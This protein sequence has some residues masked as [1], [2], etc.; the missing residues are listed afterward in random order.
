MVKWNTQYKEILTDLMKGIQAINKELKDLGSDEDYTYREP[1]QIL[2]SYMELLASSPDNKDAP[3]TSPSSSQKMSRWFFTNDYKPKLSEKLLNKKAS[4]LMGMIRRLPEE[5]AREAIRE[6]YKQR[7][8]QYWEHEIKRLEEIIKRDLKSWWLLQKSKSDIDGEIKKAKNSEWPGGAMAE[9]CTKYGKK[10]EDTL[11]KDAI[12]ILNAQKMNMQYYETDDKRDDKFRDIQ[13]VKIK[14]FG[15]Y[16][17]AFCY[18]YLLLRLKSPKIKPEVTLD[19][20]LKQLNDDDKDK[21]KNTVTNMMRGQTKLLYEKLLELVKE[22]PEKI[23]NKDIIII[24]GD[25]T[26]ED[27]KMGIGGPTRLQAKNKN[28]LTEIYDNIIKLRTDKKY[29]L[30]QEGTWAIKD[31]FKYADYINIPEEKIKEIRMKILPRFNTEFINKW[32]KNSEKLTPKQSNKLVSILFK[33]RDSKYINNTQNNTLFEDIRKEEWFLPNE[34]YFNRF[35]EL[36]G[37]FSELADI[38]I[39]AY[40]IVGEAIEILGGF[41]ELPPR[42]LIQFGEEL[43]NLLEETIKEK[44]EKDSYSRINIR[45]KLTKDRIIFE[46]L[47]ILVKHWEDKKTKIKQNLDHYNELKQIINDDIFIKWRKFTT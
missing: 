22:Y 23:S 7:S 5:R 28:W 14:E 26:D 4:K 39:K 33:E 15:G 20:F 19:T 36:D 11:I 16:C 44:L 38:F 3:P 47:Y 10:E 40:E 2:P 32:K 37:T 21:M 46:L 1:I 34:S 27:I 45:E 24:F 18:F 9:L 6:S 43:C 13:G 29:Y 17:M 42:I 25:L 41:E 31:L 30:E 35:F 12:I 8:E